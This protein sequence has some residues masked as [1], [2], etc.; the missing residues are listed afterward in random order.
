MPVPANARALR[1][2]PSLS[3]LRSIRTGT[4]TRLRAMNSIKAICAHVFSRPSGILGRLGGMVMA[5]SN[6]RMA[7]QAVKLLDVQPGDRVLEVGF[8]PGVGIQLVANSTSAQQVTGIDP[9]G[10]MVEQAAT[11]N[12]MHVE[13]GRVELG[14]GS[15]ERLP[16]AS[17]AFDKALAI[18]SMQLWPDAVDGLCE[19]QRVLRPG[20]TV[21]LGF[22]HRSGQTKDGLTELLTTAGFTDTRIVGA[23][24]EFFAL[25]RK[26]HP[27]GAL[28]DEAPPS[29]P[30]GRSRP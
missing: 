24:R 20:A 25:A 11:R 3:D 7:M 17:A 9:S 2:R 12:A 14:R 30:Y 18:R 10:E 28:S 1:V 27:A 21:V 13:A 15:V 19:I 8:G 5:R 26:P 23:H 4:D 16:F 29:A 6:R 22:T